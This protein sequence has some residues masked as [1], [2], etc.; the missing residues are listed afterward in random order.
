MLKKIL[1]YGTLLVLIAVILVVGFVTAVNYNLFGYLYT[2]KELKAFRNHNASL[3]LAEE[4]ET[5]GKIF[6]KNRTNIVYEDL[7]QHLID[8]LVATEDVRYFEHDGVDKKGMLRVFFKTLLMGDERSGGGSTITQQ[9]VKNMYGRKNFGILTMPVNKTKEAILA[10]RV[11]NVYDKNEILALYF[12]TIPFGENVFGIEAA[13]RRFYNKS[14]SKLSVDESAVLVG[15]LKAN[16][17]YNPRLYPENAKRR[18]NVVLFQMFKYGF[19]SEEEKEEL[20]QLPIKLDYANLSSE[21]I[22]NYFLQNIRSQSRSIVEQYN[23][24]HGTEWNLRTDG[25]IIKTTLD[26]QLQKQALKSFEKHLKKMQKFLRKQYQS[27]SSKRDLNRMVTAEL[28]RSGLKNKSET[29]TTYEQFNW[30]ES[31]T[32]SVTLRDSIIYSITQLHAGLLAMDPQ[33]GEVKA[34]V[35]GVDFRNFPYDQVKAKRQMASSFK[36]IL[37]AAGLENGFTPCTYL[38]NEE[39]TYTDFDN[40]KPANYNNEYGGKYSLQAALI[41]SKNVP[42]VD[43]YFNVGYENLDY[44][45]EK[46]EF[47]E[48]LKD[49][50]SSALGTVSASVY[51]LAVAYSAFANG[52]FIVEPRFIESITAPNGDVIFKAKK[53]NSSRVISDS[54]STE[55][56]YMLQQAVQRGTGMSL[57]STYGVS[58]PLAGKT[59]TSQNY[60]DAWFVSYT[61]GLVM[62][63]RV[64]ASSPNIHFNHGSYGSGSRLAL[65][66]AGYTWK[67]IQGNS[68]LRTKYVKPFGELPIDWIEAYSCN[69]FEESS[70]L[71]ELFKRDETTTVNAAKKG[72]KKRK[73][74]SKP[75]KKKNLF[76]R[77]FKKD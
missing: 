64:G 14:T 26:Y 22:A 45:W 72:K 7:P 20:Q 53:T 19:L 70:K 41:K 31:E 28:N 9:L 4:G 13:S 66:I 30:S 58:V 63:T 16:T 36:P 57:S 1:K 23:K 77:I 67:S 43:L 3:I 11:E 39:V 73:K 40:W 76:Q 6:D 2:Q 50:P 54:T 71:E 75:K 8:A 15:L 55:M 47:S 38:S 65:P 69:D 35:G 34:Y 18:R 61:P 60:A 12:N 48:E 59:G 52:G 42:T 49:L 5:L 33:S 74:K 68:R 32:D 21:G 51:E 27:G 17:Y 56:T 62:V 37:Y 44:L 29:Y 25:L 24:D 46:L 10:T